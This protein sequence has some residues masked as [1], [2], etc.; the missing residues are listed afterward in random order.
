M[1]LISG[2]EVD[3]PRAVVSQAVMGILMAVFVGLCLRSF[4][5]A[6]RAR[7]KSVE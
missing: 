5:E 7:S 2:T 1:D 6:R 4:I 3:R